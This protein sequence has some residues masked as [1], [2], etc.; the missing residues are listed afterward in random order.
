MS[1]NFNIRR[2]IREELEH[3][4][5]RN[6]N[7]FSI[8][9]KITRIPGVKKV[10]D[11]KGMVDGFAALVRYED[12][13]VYEIQVT[14]ASLIKDKEFWGDILKQKT[15]PMKTLYKDLLNTKI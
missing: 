3:L 6:T 10:L 13:N 9:S 2:F 7:A 15:H 4:E 1:S 8:T 5:E 14:P 11:M 12:G